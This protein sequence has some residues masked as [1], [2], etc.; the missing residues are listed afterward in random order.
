MLHNC[1]PQSASAGLP[2][3][4]CKSLMA[5]GVRVC[6]GYGLTETMNA[7]N[8]SNLKAVLPGSMGPTNYYAEE[9][10]AEDGELLV[11]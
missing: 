2:P 5:M 4:L 10:I 8:F 11:Q 9:K 3:N 6:E 7:V 1:Q